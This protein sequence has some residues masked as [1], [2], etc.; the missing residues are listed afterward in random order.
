MVLIIIKVEN[1]F[2]SPVHTKNDNYKDN[3]ISIHT[4]RRYRLYILS[5]RASVFLN[6]QARYSRID[7]DWLSM[8]L[9]FISWTKNRS[10]SDSNDIVSL[11]LYRYSCGVDSAIL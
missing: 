4:S 11:C 6:Y 2:L 1:S 9:L 10:E 8:F 3:N 5:A 7:S